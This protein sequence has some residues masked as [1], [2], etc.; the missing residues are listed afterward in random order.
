[1]SPIGL[2]VYA[3]HFL[4]AAKAA[5]VSQ[6]STPARFPFAPA[7]LFLVC[8][9]I[10]LL[11]KAFPSLKGNSLKSL[12]SNKFGHDLEKLL[13]DAEECGLGE[14][15]QLTPPL[16]VEIRKASEYYAEKVFEYPALYEAVQAYPRLPD[17]EPLLEAADA[18]LVALNEPCLNS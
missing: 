5:P 3:A 6:Q 17:F 9:A 12:A 16:V 13:Q 15:I 1:M 14:L 11:L 7:R 18:L 2:H 4:D 8:H 10:E